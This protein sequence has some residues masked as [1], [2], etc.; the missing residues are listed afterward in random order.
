MHVVPLRNL[1]R[2]DAATFLRVRGVPDGAHHALLSFTGGN[3]LAL[4]LAAAVVVRQD[5]DGT[6]R[7]A[8]WAPGRDVI[9]TLLPRLVGDPPSPAHRTALEV[10]AQADVTSEALLRAMMGERAPEL[11]AWLRTQPFIE[12]TPAGLFPHDVVRE[13]LAADLR[14]R[15]PDGFAA[16]RRRM[17]EYLLGRVR[18][19]SAAQILPAMQA[20]VYLHRTLGHLAKAF[21]WHSHGLV[22]EL[23]CTPADEK[24]VVELVQE[25]EGPESAALARF[26][27]D[28]QPE[29]FVVY[30]STGTDDIVAC[31][32]LAATRRAGRGGRRSGGGRRLG[33]CAYG[34]AVASG[35]AVAVARF[36]VTRRR[37]SGLRPP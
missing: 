15:D 37:T 32:R 2:G 36:H 25:T 19:A 14:W 21:E 9:A 1:A 24:R 23:P 10:C 3:P 29:A 34:R 33:P 30:R 11:F 5:A 16:L 7:A 28:R 18:E 27:L 22:R 13:V 35:G 20:L 26:W 31:L 12:S 4:S 6:A 8:D 17:Y